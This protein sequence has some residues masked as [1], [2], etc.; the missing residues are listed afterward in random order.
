M[1]N[2]SDICVG[3]EVWLHHGKKNLLSGLVLTCYFVGKVE[4]VKPDM[5]FMRRDQA[6][7]GAWFK[8]P[9]VNLHKI[10]KL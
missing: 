8:Q 5:F 10:N 6:M 2:G 3:D 1:E 7:L 9:S 4:R